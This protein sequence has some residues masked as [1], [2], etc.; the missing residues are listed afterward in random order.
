MID[1]ARPTL[2]EEKTR[3]LLRKLRD[4]N[5]TAGPIAVGPR[6]HILLAGCA[7]IDAPAE[8][9]VRYRLRLTDGS[10]GMLE[11]QGRPRGLELE[12]TRL[13]AAGGR[14]LLVEMTCDRSGRACSRALAARVT[15]DTSDTRELEHFLRRIV[16]ALFAG[17]E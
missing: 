8:C 13:G 14:R 9:G 3:A 17:G 11:I 2:S 4:L 7:S 6:T 5:L 1:L 10:Q 16:R 15:P 12:L